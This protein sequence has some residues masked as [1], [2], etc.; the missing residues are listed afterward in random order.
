MDFCD[1]MQQQS[2]EAEYHQS[3]LD[4]NTLNVAVKSWI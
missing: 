1:I 2:P 3:V 4:C